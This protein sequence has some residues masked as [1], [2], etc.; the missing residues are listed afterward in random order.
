MKL[1]FL[2][3]IALA[4]VAA[5]GCVKTVTES[6]AFRSNYSKDTIAGRYNRTPDQVYAAA[7]TVIQQNG[8]VVTEFIPHTATNTVRSLQGKVNQRDVYISVEAVEPKI[9]EVKVQALGSWG[10]ADLD[11]T[12]ELEKEIALQLAR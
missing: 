11:L 10:N 2:A 9:T 3:V 7:L 6:H 4:A 5:T 1:K 8:V 12:H